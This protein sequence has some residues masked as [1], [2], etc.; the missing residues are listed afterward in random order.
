MVSMIVEPT[1]RYQGTLKSANLPP[2]IGNLS[3]MLSSGTFALTKR[4]RRT[5]L[6]NS[7]M[8]IFGIVDPFSSVLFLNL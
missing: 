7:N 3:G 2:N 5:M 1:L 6:I 4:R 8:K